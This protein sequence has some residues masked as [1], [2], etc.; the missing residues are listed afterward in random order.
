MELA[1]HGELSPEEW[2][3]RFQRA[4]EASM[5]S[6]FATEEDRGTLREL[7]FDSREDGVWATVSFSMASHPGITFIRSQRVMPD[8]S[9]EEDPDF[10]A[11]LLGIHL[12]E[13]FYTE[14]RKKTPDADGIIRN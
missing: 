10:A 9:A 4:A 11:M 14:A 3:E 5:R 13:W 7:V 1:V 8:L 6:Q 2:L 12:I